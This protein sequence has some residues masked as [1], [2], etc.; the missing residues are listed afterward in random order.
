M[1]HRVRRIFPLIPWTVALIWGV[2]GETIGNVVL[3]VEVGPVLGCRAQTKRLWVQRLTDKRTF[4]S[5]RVTDAAVVFE[6]IHV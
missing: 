2:F 4:Q 3:H 5:L 1:L 6:S